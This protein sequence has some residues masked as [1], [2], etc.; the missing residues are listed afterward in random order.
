VKVTAV[1]TPSGVTLKELYFLLLQFIV[2]KNTAFY[3][4]QKSFLPFYEYFINIELIGM[5]IRN[6]Y[7]KAELRTLL[8]FKP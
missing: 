8:L 1:P 7:F 5:R 2:V 3:K 6:S 4:K